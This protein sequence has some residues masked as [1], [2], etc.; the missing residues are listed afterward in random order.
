MIGADI[1]LI[2]GLFDEPQAQKLRVEIV[3]AFCIGRYRRQMMNALQL[4]RA[5]SDFSVRAH[6]MEV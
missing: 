3:I 6:H 4:H 1:V 5:V 2:D